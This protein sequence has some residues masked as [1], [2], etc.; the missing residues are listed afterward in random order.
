M[1]EPQRLR[2]VDYCWVPQGVRR[3]RVQCRPGHLRV[4]LGVRVL[5]LLQLGQLALQGVDRH[6]YG[7]HHRDGV[8]EAHHHVGAEY[9]GCFYYYSYLLLL[10]AALYTHL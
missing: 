1:V 6:P 8:G 4:H 7:A 10:S 9:Y 3:L 5:P 2:L